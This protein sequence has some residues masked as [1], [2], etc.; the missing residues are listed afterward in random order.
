VKRRSIAKTVSVT[1]TA[2]ALMLLGVSAFSIYGFMSYRN[3]ISDLSIN[4]LPQIANSA[5][6]SSYL[7]KLNTLTEQLSRAQST[8]NLRIAKSNVDIHFTQLS[9]TV[10]K[11]KDLE[12]RNSLIQQIDMLRKNLNSLNDLADSGIKAKEKTK[13][14]MTNLLTIVNDSRALT[15]SASHDVS[16][17]LLYQWSV[18]VFDITELARTAKDL[19]SLSKVRKI[20]KQIGLKLELLKTLIK[21]FPAAKFNAFIVLATQLEQQSLG[22]EGVTSS[23]D[24]QIRAFGKLAGRGNFSRALVEEVDALFSSQ[25][26]SINLAAAQK[27][28]DLLSAVN[29]QIWLQIGL[30]VSILFVFGGVH[31]Y[32]KRILTNRLLAMKDA[33]LLRVEGKG[34]EITITHNDEITDI[35]SSINYFAGEL[36]LASEAAKASNQS[37]SEFL[38]NMS[39]EIRTPMNAIIGL[40]YLAL[41]TD[42]TEQQKDYIS[43]VNSSS[44]ALLGIIND[45]LDFSKIEAGKLIMEQAPFDLATVINDLSHLIVAPADNKR[46]NILISCPNNVPKYLIG[47]SLRL[48]QI[49]LNLAGNA[50]KFTEGGEIMISI[51]QKES[52]GKSVILIFSVKDTGI[53]MTE[54]Q[55]N[56]LFQS[57]SQADSST[58]RKFGGTGL[59]LTISKQLVTMMDGEINVESEPNVGS[60][61]FF[62]ARFGL[63]H[64]RT[65]NTLP[66]VHEF[67]KKRVLIIDSNQTAQ[68]IVVEIIESLKFEVHSVSSSKA[69]LREIQRVSNNADLPS[70]DIVF[71]DEKMSNL[72]GIEIS[73]L[74]KAEIKEGSTFSII[75]M[76][77]FNNIEAKALVGKGLFECIIEKPVTQSNVYDAIVNVID[78]DTN[79]NVQDSNDTQAKAFNL[80]GI[81]V[82]LVED[83]KINQQVASEL[84]EK[85]GI[86]VTVVDNGQEA[87]D[88]MAEKGSTFDLIL[89]DIQMPLLDGYQATSEIRKSYDYDTLPILAMTAHAMAGEKEKSISNGMNEHITKPIDPDLLYTALQKWSKRKEALKTPPAVKHTSVVGVTEDELP[90]ELPG[91]DIEIAVRQ[92]GGNRKL[93]KKLLI[94]F[95]QDYHSVTESMRTALKENDYSFIHRTAHSLKGVS[96]TLGAKDIQLAAANLENVTKNERAGECLSHIDHLEQH[97]N[98]LLDGLASLSSDL[99]DKAEKIRTPYPKGDAI[100]LLPLFQALIIS[101]KEG[102]LESS[103]LFEEI[104]IA[105]RD[106]KPELPMN[107]IKILIDDFEFQDALELLPDIAKGIGI[108][109]D[110]VK[111]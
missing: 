41:K 71:L 11:I 46:T 5:E 19:S 26:L 53:G 75:M 94:E 20:Q 35:A 59:G 32:F 80:Q 40:S 3:I 76:T 28:D 73:R 102:L 12:L 23:K 97:A 60:N 104:E 33:V 54:E 50:I 34:G 111:E 2:M 27:S 95:Y 89:M 30:L 107:E 100:D 90:T 44:L 77:G 17:E 105:V 88:I 16:A 36:E 62:T 99:T 106:I 91:F 109:L 110:K 55:M 51:S 65:K 108:K 58:T 68:N 85:Q 82:L 103:S 6:V 13:L 18:G 64:E 29:L 31:F 86:H 74:I 1:L 79:Y 10:D 81:N 78:R 45:I 42:L 15:L 56:K 93:L 4:T 96:G 83:N 70:Y 37:K 43:K 67:T 38:A 39:H 92:I 52:I 48:G 24:K 84:L 9:L 57:F 87:V 22:K 61:F 25:F 7:D 49:L 21:K 14:A 69:G 72:N 101:L 98:F 66:I 8:P 47:D 63:N